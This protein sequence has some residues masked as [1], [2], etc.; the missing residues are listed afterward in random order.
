MMN[1]KR[2]NWILYL[3][4]ITIITTI[5]VQF[6]WNYKNY[7][8]NKQR[9]LNEI[10]ISLDNA[11]EKYYADLS[12]NNFFKDLESQFFHENLG[13][14]LNL[15]L[16]KDIDNYKNEKITFHIDPIKIN[17]NHNNFTYNKTIVVDSIGYLKGVPDFFKF[18]KSDIHIKHFSGTPEIQLS[19][20]VKEVDSLKLIKSIQTIYNAIKNDSLNYK[21]IDSIFKKELKSKGIHSQYYF[22]H[23]KKDTVFFSNKIKSTDCFMGIEAKSTF[24]RSDENFK[25][26]YKNPKIEALKRSSTGILLSLILSIIIIMSLFF[27]LKTINKQKELAE[28]KNDLISNIT[29]EFKTPIATVSI[30]IEAIESFNVLNDA[31]KTQKYLKMSSAQLKKLHQMVEKLLETAALDSE[32]LLLKRENIDVVELLDV[33][34]NKHQTINAEKE[35]N[36]LSNVDKKNI[37]IDIFHFE[38]AVSNLIDNAIKYGGNKIEVSLNAVFNNIE[39]IVSD[40]G[41]G[42][43]KHQQEK[44]FDKFYRVPK[45]NTHNI[46]GF[47]IG[48]YYSKKIIEKHHGNIQLVINNKNTI[49]KIILPDE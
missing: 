4:T 9:V 33:L 43:E 16:I 26:F 12:K 22:N 23:S 6:Y 31:D 37:N 40:N 45:G 15:S 28:I 24:L 7:E 8:E 11:I 10:Q 21:D 27:L 1:N 20:K 3:I 14:A 29:H 18:Q 48:L 38:N 44:I 46:K 30:A 19:S 36:F 2:H 25:L 47:G 17:G 39:I 5:G 32:S 42:I 34:V 41:N 49:F 35:L 13:E